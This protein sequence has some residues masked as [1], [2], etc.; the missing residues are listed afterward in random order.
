MSK[1]KDLN[2]QLELLI[3]MST[4]GYLDV[5]KNYKVIVYTEPLGNPSFHLKYKNQ[6]EIVLKLS[7]LSILEVKKG[8]FEKGQLLPTKI[9][10]DLKIFLNSIYKSDVTYWDQLLFLWNANNEKFPI[11]LNRKLPK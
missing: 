10:K 9:S 11:S 7:D 1:I 5:A 6:W 3:E 8:K 2:E 4:V